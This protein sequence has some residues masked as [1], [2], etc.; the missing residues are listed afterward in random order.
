VSRRQPGIPLRELAGI[1]PFFA[2]ST[3][4][5]DA[6][7]GWRRASALIG[8]AEVLRGAVNGVAARLGGGRRWIAA[9][10][11]YQAWAA[12]L[13]SVYAGSAA[14]CGAVPDLRADRLFYR[15]RRSGPVELAAAPPLEAVSVEAGWRHMHDD[16]LVLLAEAIRRHVRIGR[17]LLLGNEASALAGSLTVLASARGESVQAL[18]G[19]DWARP[20]ELAPAGRWMSAPGGPRFA[21]TTCCGYELVDGGGRCGDC[22]LNWRRQ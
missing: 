19:H 3:G 1:G 6:R 8:D 18:L 5:T 2:L 17:Y 13:T 4:P 11:F 14:L 22:S 15:P 21:R 16:H 10:L 12:Q 7:S 20:A 9:S